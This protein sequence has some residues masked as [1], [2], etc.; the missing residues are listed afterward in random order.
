MAERES[1]TV[2]EMLADLAAHP[3]DD[4]R[5]AMA[6]ALR[7][8]EAGALKAWDIVGVEDDDPVDFRQFLALGFVN[9]AFPPKYCLIP[10]A[11]DA[12]TQS[13]MDEIVRA[14]VAERPLRTTLEQVR[15]LTDDPVVTLVHLGF[16][17]KRGTGET[18]I[19]LWHH[20]DIS[21]RR[22][23]YLALLA[24]ESDRRHRLA[25]GS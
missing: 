14:L 13:E 16:G 10:G 9:G 2:A 25:R 23:V 20:H 19:G 7:E 12:E 4:A 5:H 11:D 15:R 1:V 21:L 8:A 17:R 22:A 6:N 24:I 18:A 3:P